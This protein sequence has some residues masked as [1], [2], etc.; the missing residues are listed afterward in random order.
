MASVLLAL[1]M[2][3]ATAGGEVERIEAEV[4]PAWPPDSDEFA[5][6]FGAGCS[7]GCAIDWVFTATSTLSPIGDIDYDPENVDDIDPATA[8]VEGVDGPGT[9]E[10]LCAEFRRYTAE[11]AAGGDSVNF[12]GM[13][14]QNGYAKDEETWRANGRIHE[15][16]LY[17]NGELFAIAELADVMEAQQVYWGEI[18]YVRHGDV[19]EMEIISVYEGERWQ[20]TAISGVMLF[21]AH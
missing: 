9:G 16:G 17:L 12:N 10:R 4:Q 7:L 19:F 21:G 18:Q 5:L 15:L 3:Q 20:D 13:T 2:M 1:L 14:I 11:E 8:W 6:L